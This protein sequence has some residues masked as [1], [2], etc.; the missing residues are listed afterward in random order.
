M[1]KSNPIITRWVTHRLEN[2]NTK[3]ILTLLWRFWSLH[4]TS[5][6]GNLSKGLRIPKNLALRASRS[7]YRS[8]RGLR[9]TDC[10]LGGHKQN[11][12]YTKT[13]RRAVLTPQDTEPKLP[14][15]VRGAPAEVWIGRGSPQGR[16]HWEVLIDVDPRAGL[17][18]AKQ[19]LRRGEGVQS[20]PSADNWIKPL[21]S[22]ALPTRARPSFSHRQSLPSRRELACQPHPSEG[23][24]K[25]Q[26]EAHLTVAKTKTVLLEDNHDEKE[27]YI[28]VE[29]TR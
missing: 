5:Q 15:S 8:S 11:F 21:P 4:Q 14:A 17:P 18:Q 2:N 24:Q 28:P 26:E 10:S 23:R 9:E 12:A 16:G 25:M 3:E 13:Q 1:I 6:H 19:L 20:H 29:G 7:Y 27:C 22:K